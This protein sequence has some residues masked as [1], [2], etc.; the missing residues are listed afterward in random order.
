MTRERRGAVDKVDF[1]AAQ[2]SKRTVLDIGC[3]DHRVSMSDELGDRWLHARISDT[4]SVAVGIDYLAA[5]VDA[6]RGRGFDI[7][8]ENAQDFDLGRRFDVVV[9]AD[10]IEHLDD[11]GGFLASAKRHVAPGG[12]L[13][14][15][16]NNPFDVEQMVQVLRR[17]APA[18]HPDHTMWLD[19]ST[20]FRALAR[21]DLDDS[22]VDFIWLSTRYRAISGG[23]VAARVARRICSAVAWFRPVCGAEYAVVLQV[24]EG[25]SVA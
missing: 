15:T 20:M 21:A 16:T 13:I 23:G 2:C 7:R 22:I 9:A 24:T 11:V 14:I 12:R 5:D 25:E 6:L 18:V 8:C 10:I 19:P 4:A 17:Q 1:I 3:V